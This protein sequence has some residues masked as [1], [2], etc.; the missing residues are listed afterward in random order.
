MADASKEQVQT[1]EQ[2]PV[3]LAKTRAAQRIKALFHSKKEANMNDQRAVEEFLKQ[4]SV[5][6]KSFDKEEQLKK[7]DYKIWYI[8]PRPT[9]ERRLKQAA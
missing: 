2:D 9:L 5:E 6:K 4:K 7:L 1:P 8:A 3:L